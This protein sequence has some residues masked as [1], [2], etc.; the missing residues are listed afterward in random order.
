MPDSVLDK[1]RAAAAYAQ[2]KKLEA[3]RKIESAAGGGYAQQQ[4]AQKF[5]AFR[6]SLDQKVQGALVEQAASH[7]N[8]VGAKL[9]DAYYKLATTKVHMPGVTP[10][11][12]TPEGTVNGGE[13]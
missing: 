1:L 11:S 10:G 9:L 12:A 6:E 13:L 5:D 4:R 2:A 3:Q 8:G 7:P